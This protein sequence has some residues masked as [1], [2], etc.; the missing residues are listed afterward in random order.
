MNNKSSNNY[1]KKGYIKKLITR[2][3]RKKVNKKDIIKP[4]NINEKKKNHEWISIKL[5]L[6]ISNVLIAIIPV[7]VIAI[8]LFSSGRSSILNEVEQANMALAGQ[9]TELI[10]F[11]LSEI[12][13]SSVLLSSNMLLLETMSKSKEDYDNKY[14]MTADREKN[15]YPLVISLQEANPDLK[16]VIFVKEDEVVTREQAVGAGIEFLFEKDFT[17]NFINGEIYQKASDEQKVASWFYGIF[18]R[19]NLM[20]VSDISNP[21]ASDMKTAL[22]IELDPEYLLSVLKVDELGKGAKMSLVDQS[23][24]VIVSS[25]ETLEMGTMSKVAIELNKHITD[26][27]EIN[28]SDTMPVSNSFITSENVDEEIM[29]VYKETKAGWRYV[30]EIPTASIF[31]GI[32]KMSSLALIIVIISLVLAVIFG[33]ILAINIVKPIDYIR[34]K[35]KE[36]E[37]GNL[38]VRSG[39]KGNF[40]IGQLSH[41]FNT[42]T[43]NMAQLIKKT[44]SITD[45]VA[46]DSEELMKIASQSALA[47][48]EVIEAVESLSE[49]ATEQSRDAEKAS[50]VIGELISQ[51]KKTEES[52]K[53]VVLVT[54]RTKNASKE[55][56]G[57][58]VELNSTTAETIIL[59][60]NIKKDMGNLTLKF[61]EILG[62]ID[63]INAISSQT[64]LLALNAAIE[65]ARAGESGKGFAVVADEVRKLASQSSDAAKNISDIVN[66][67]HLATS[68]T[69]N[70]I[71]GGAVIYERQEKAAK[72]TEKTFSDIVSDMDNIILEVD[73]VYKLLSG[74]EI[75]QD[76]ATDSIS[77][78]A[79]ITEE[80]SAAIE[81]VLATGIEQTDVADHLSFMASKLSSVIETMNESIKEFRV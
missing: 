35:M 49:G 5:K 78:I 58:I 60:N 39:F 77:S 27:S 55:A 19:K 32:N 8:L 43:E 63:I 81:E 38:T 30:A 16:R 28:K 46:S 12:E 40:E 53:Q 79:T 72:N 62:I 22:L 75:I 18:E 1:Q 36:V 31:G 76:K 14:F 74:L 15:I 51:M 10:N 70:M 11:K 56:G 24:K 45:E 3:K 23:G 50:G 7:I 21:F 59:F 73:Q 26:N 52:F 65:A 54:N 80:S 71:E 66:N 17:S 34:S 4:I 47:S 20:M 44:G 42:M 48:K 25:D 33:I 64:N 6:T 2:N 9:V 37:S 57:T 29:V 67:I 69:E 68:Q 13:R 41:S 61:K